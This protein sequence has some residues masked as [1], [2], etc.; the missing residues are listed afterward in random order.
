MRHILL[1]ILLASSLFQGEAQNWKQINDSVVYY[2]KTKQFLKAEVTVK[3]AIPA[4]EKEFGINHINY[5]TSIENLRIIYWALKDYV[6][7][8]PLIETLLAYYTRQSNSLKQAGELNRLAIA[9]EKTGNKQNAGKYYLD[10][11]TILKSSGDYALLSTAFYNAGNFYKSQQEFHMADTLF[12]QSV[13]VLRNQQGNRDLLHQMTGASALYYY[14]RKEYIKGDPL[15]L[16]YL[17]QT[18]VQK[19]KESEAYITT[20]EYLG[21]IYENRRLFEKAVP[22]FRQ[23]KELKKKTK[24]ETSPEYASFLT[25]MVVLYKE[26]MI[27]DSAIVIYQEILKLK[28]QTVGKFHSQYFNNLNNLGRLYETMGDYNKAIAAQQELLFLK[29]NSIGKIDTSYSLTLNNLAILH[30]KNNNYYK[31]EQLYLELLQI[32]E[33]IFG[34]E[35]TAY[36]IAI[37]NL[38]T[39]YEQMGNYVKAF[40]Y[41][42]PAKEVYGKLNGKNSF[43]Y[44]KIAGNLA[45]LYAQAGEPQKA[46]ALYQEVL[47]IIE[48]TVGRSHVD[49][50]TP[51][52]NLATLFFKNENFKAAEPLFAEALLLLEKTKGKNHPDYANTLHNLG[53]LHAQTGDYENAEREITAAMLIIE[54]TLGKEHIRYASSL[55]ILATIYSKTSNFTKAAPLFLQ[56]INLIERQYGKENPDYRAC[57]TRYAGYQQDIGKFQE[58]GQLYRQLISTVETT[59]GKNNLD[60]ANYLNDYGTLLQ[61]QGK[62]GETESLY[63][64]ALTIIE[65]VAGK[66]NTY[67]SFCLNNLASLYD[68]LGQYEKAERLY[69]QVIELNKKILGAKNPD[70]M[71]GL[72][73]LAV[74]YSKMGEHA[75]AD[76]LYLLAMEL[77][78]SIPGEE[79]LKLIS[80]MTNLAGSYVNQGL[81]EKAET[82]YLQLKQLSEKIYGGQSAQYGD[83]LAGLATLYIMEG[84]FIKAETILLQEAEIR[85]NTV[86]EKHPLYATNLLNMGEL[87]TDSKQYQKAESVYLTAGKIKLDNLA[88]IFYSLS[89]KEK[90][91]Y[92]TNKIGLNNTFNSFIY[93]YRKSSPDFIKG[94]YN[95][96][97][98]LKSLTLSDTKNVIESVRNSK[99]TV[100]QKVYTNWLS[101]KAVLSRQYAL[102]VAIRRKDLQNIEVQTEDYEKEI[103]RKSAVYKANQRA[104]QIKYS[105]LQKLLQEDEVAIEF[106]KFE[107]YNR[108]W[109]DSIMYAAYILNKKDSAPVFVPLCEEKQLQKLFDS[110]G[111]TTTAMV[112]KFYRGLDL[113]NSGTVTSLGKDLYSLVWAPLEP[114]LKGIKKISYSPAGKLYSIAFHALPVDSVT[115]LMD[116]YQLQQYT[117][118]RQV[119][120]REQE[121]QNSKPQ[122]IALF[123]DASFTLDSLQI[124][125]GKTKTENVTSNIYT[126]QNRGTRGGIWSNLPG[127]AQEVKTIQKV[128]EQNKITTKSFTQITA[129]EENLKALNNNSPQILHIA[130]HGFF[131]PEIEDIKKLV[132]FI[133]HENTYTLAKNPLLRSGLILS[134]G[135]YAWSGK[136]PID[137]V[138]DG[139]ATAYEI[140]QLNLSNTELVVLSACETALG[141]VKGSEGV[142]GLQRAF[143]M[144]G[145]KKMIVSLWQVP[146]KETAELMTSFYGYWMKGK[147]INDAFTQAQADMRK[148]YAPFYWAAFVLVE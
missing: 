38:G 96:Q 34:K 42:E 126:P 138:E 76:T 133:N 66:S 103:T 5:I 21:I 71:G 51:L 94:N 84:D 104:T 10:A 121:I 20:L 107:L 14:D 41:L 8:I 136:T 48:R 74:L 11:I 116:K 61:A 55:N 110:A 12:A 132:G 4:A 100:L 16:E 113:G 72:N 73:N 130:T 54:Q 112:S 53:A 24:G 32:R 89:E 102:P 9:Y 28:E 83:V 7:A 52:Q 88:S 22:V 40:L 86:G 46:E 124:V 26:A 59:N 128:F 58:A 118:T 67:Y 70:N 122:N 82:L 30:K 39:M 141:D 142:F 140:S 36:A 29:E 15:Y 56:S 97:L 19:G 98:G 1:L 115:V 35:S 81:N 25:S 147:T 60:Y 18:G 63:L 68:I 125:K 123:G 45:L 117:S 99:D 145:V 146:D 75:K 23:V 114:Y 106:V 95:L 101:G 143:K 139:I 13:S 92:L 80:V 134:G 43:E 137:G 2:Q 3:K 79:N 108:I 31:A 90:G 49:Y 69:R 37:N 109:T 129:S 50:A 131:L 119:V 144:A 111:A 33:K 77:A 91:N 57:L 64:Q 65:Q 17:E 62:Y 78:K 93:Y 27:Y 87:Y 85:K 6:K 135:N 47:T 127:T 105:E 44:A 148:K 120:L